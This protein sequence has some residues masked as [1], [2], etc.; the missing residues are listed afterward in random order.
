[1]SNIVPT[2]PE[3]TVDHYGRRLMEG[4]VNLKF[5]YLAEGRDVGAMTLQDFW[6]ETRYVRDTRGFEGTKRVEVMVTTHTA[7]RNEDP[8]NG[9]GIVEQ[10]YN[11]KVYSSM[12]FD[13]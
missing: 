13:T 7:K 1:M 4:T 12:E 2:I 3:D 10:P 5:F 11:R 8:Y 9:T 6:F